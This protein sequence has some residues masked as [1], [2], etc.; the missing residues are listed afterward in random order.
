AGALLALGEEE[1]ARP[2][3]LK[4]LTSRKDPVRALAI[5]IAGELAA[6]WALEALREL[7]ASRAG[8]RWCDEIDAAL[9]GR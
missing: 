8:A 7:R 9:A 1:S 5:Q 6:P 4:A 2:K 3:L